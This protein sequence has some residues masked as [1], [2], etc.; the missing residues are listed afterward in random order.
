LRSSVLARPLLGSTTP[1]ISTP[2]L[3][4]GRRGPCGCGCAL[5]PQTS[6]G[7]S[8]VDFATDV[9]GI[10]PLPWQRWLLIHALEL[11]PDGSFRF[12]TVLIL[13]ARQNGKTSMIEVKNLWKLFVLQVPLVV[14]TA[15]DLDVSEESWDKAIEIIEAIP[16]LNAELVHVN[17]VNG[18]K[19]F[20]LASGSRWKPKASTRRSARGLAGDDVNLDELREHTNWLAWAAVTKTTMARANAQVYAFS[21]A[22]DDASMVLND[23]QEQGRAAATLP[24]VADE[25]L[26]YFEW[27]APDD[28]KC[29]CNRKPHL[30]DCRL[31]DRAAWAMANPALGYTI[32]EQALAS[33]LAT[34]P[35]AVFRTECLCQRVQSMSEWAV[36][37]KPD[38]QAAQDPDSTLATPPAYCVELNRELDTIS[39]G[40]AGRRADGKRHLELVERFPA[41]EGKLIGNLKKKKAQF[42]PVAIVVDPAGPANVFIPAIEKHLQIE[43]FRPIGRDVAGAC[44]SIYV[45]IAGQNLEARD[46]KVRP[47]PSLDAAAKSADWRDRGDAK[48]FDRRNED[49]PDVAPLMAVTL[50]DLGYALKAGEA[51][52]VLDSVADFGTP[53]EHW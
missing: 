12:R 47:H 33:A 32:T 7:F 44:T 17:K 29:T 46:V 38:W 51:Y 27:S 52:S 20:K 40:A 42:G 35:E 36:F 53:D 11:R 22:G 3:V 28:V 9:L 24:E 50:A 10:P 13:V 19:Y 5:T 43:V 45:G 39:I 4:V 2:P 25:S 15:Q 26:G 30:D 48:A 8:A 18:K 14:S 31:Q 37:A 34:D 21:N 6:L 23:L 1:R 16:E 41:D 49:G